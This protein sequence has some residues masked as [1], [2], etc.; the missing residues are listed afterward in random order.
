MKV[1]FSRLCLPCTFFG[2]HGIKEPKAMSTTK[3]VGLHHHSLLIAQL[4][5]HS[6][7]NRR[8]TSEKNTGIEEQQIRKTWINGGENKSQEKQ[9]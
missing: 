6:S 8:T 9:K 2:K 4:M 1:H 5:I 7:D 3:F